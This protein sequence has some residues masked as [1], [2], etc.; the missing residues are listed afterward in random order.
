MHNSLTEDV[1]QQEQCKTMQTEDQAEKQS[2]TNKVEETKRD[3]AMFN[4]VHTD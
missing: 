1:F 2:S 4:S 3:Y